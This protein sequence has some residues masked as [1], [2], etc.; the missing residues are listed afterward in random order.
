[1]SN[2]T[3][4][5]TDATIVLNCPGYGSFTID[6]KGAGSVSVG[7]ATTRSVQDVA[8]D[9]SIMTSKIAGNNGS[10]NFSVQQ[11]SALD[12]W[13]VGLFNYL[14]SADTDEWTKVSCTIRAP[15]M[16][17]QHICKGGSMEKEADYTYAAQGGQV[18]WNI[19]F[20]D[21][22]NLNI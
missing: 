3:Y 14:W 2:S 18:T 9:G 21:I 16:R 11:T 20:D 8:A 17:K 22:Q 13:L 12:D 15:K 10:C 6:K 7:K 4:S 19:L 1:M 5:F